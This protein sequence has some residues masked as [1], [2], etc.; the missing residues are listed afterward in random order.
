MNG[1]T[2]AHARL[3]LE[4][5]KTDEATKLLQSLPKDAETLYL[6]GRLNWKK[7][8]IAKAISYFEEASILEP[9][10]EATQA[11]EMAREVMDFYNK[12]MYNP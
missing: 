10:G 7:G 5:N 3:L 2:K 1:D 9:G 8:N 6:L 12:D 11:L 4:S